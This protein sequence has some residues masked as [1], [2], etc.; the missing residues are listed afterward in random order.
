VTINKTH[1]NKTLHLTIEI[2][3][4]MIERLVDTKASMSIMAAN[5]VRELGI[6]HLVAGHEA[7]K[8]TSSIIT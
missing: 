3:Q 4:I 7:Y 6:V 1:Y 2:N 5:V 8:T